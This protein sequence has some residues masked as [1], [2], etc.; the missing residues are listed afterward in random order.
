MHGRRLGAASGL[1]FSFG[2][3][4]AGA[5]YS[6]RHSP[7]QPRIWAWYR[8]LRKPSYT[9]PS[10]VFGTV[11][12]AMYMLMATSCYR[13]WRARRG[14]GR[15]RAL[16]QWT[17]RGGLNTLWSKLFFGQRALR[18]SLVDLGALL[19][20]AITYLRSAFRVD[21]WAGILAVPYVGWLGFA[22]LLNAEIARRNPQ[23]A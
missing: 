3:V 15:S 18:W 17:L 14:A 4:L 7:E 11:W 23:R 1:L 8:A 22:A 2:S 13:I 19:V 9:P 20:S 12:T 16:A 5:I 10:W 21:R 6:R